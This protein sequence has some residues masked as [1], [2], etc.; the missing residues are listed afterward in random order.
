VFHFLVEEACRVVFGTQHSQTPYR[1]A[2]G[3]AF[4]HTTMKQACNGFG[5]GT[6]KDS[7]IKGLPRN[8]DGKYVI[9]PATKRLASTF[10]E[11]QENRHV[12]DYDRSERFIRSDVWSL[13]EE[14]RKRV[15]DFEA[16]P[17]GDEKRFFL[18]C[19]WA[20]KELSSR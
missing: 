4:T 11:L 5:G 17:L 3:R 13:I 8:S 16:I 20:W 14:A 7:V 15:A 9:F 10:A 19:L 18:A 12:A 1:N 2:L 6:L